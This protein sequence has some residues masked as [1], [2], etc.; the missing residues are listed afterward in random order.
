MPTLSELETNVHSRQEAFDW[1][2]RH[3][4]EQGGP[5]R[6]KNTCLY[7]CDSR[8]CAFGWLIPD[9]YYSRNFEGKIINDELLKTLNFIG[10]SDYANYMRN[11][12]IHFFRLLQACHD[13][14]QNDKNNWV[15][16]WSSSGVANMLQS[17]AKTY[18]LD[19]KVLEQSFP[20]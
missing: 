7:R 8:C 9:E 20:K 10:I 5:S 14:A 16:V 3:L 15:N 1:V 11:E 18:N 17:F 12:K 19:T 13:H 4:A 6:T 2:V